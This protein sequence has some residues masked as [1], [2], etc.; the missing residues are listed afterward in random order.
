MEKTILFEDG[1]LT[2]NEDGTKIYYNGKYI[3][4]WLSKSK[5][6]T[7]GYMMC[8]INKKH[9]YTHRLVALVF[10][11]NPN[12]FPYVTHLNTNSLDNY[13]KNLAWGTRRFIIQNM[14]VLR[15]YAKSHES[16]PNSKISLDEAIK[17]ACP[18]RN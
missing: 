7:N 16:R 5:N 18:L 2:I 4:Q 11:L 8:N 6:H 15:R 14:Q 1:K 3:N 13:F 9:R 10:N 17:I 12:N